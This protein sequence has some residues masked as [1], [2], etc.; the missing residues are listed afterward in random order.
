MLK[1]LCKKMF[2]KSL[3]V[4]HCNSG[5][6]NGCDIE[7]L[8]ILTPYYDVERFGIKLVGSPRHADV[9]LIS[10]AVTRPTLP[11]VKKAYEAMPN[12]KL[13]FAIGSCA[14]G[15]GAWFDTYNVTGG[16]NKAVPINYYI[17]GCPPR[18]EAILYGVAL[19]LGLVDKKVAPIELK[20]MEFP[21]DVYERNKAWEER[22]V[23]YKLLEEP[24][25][26]KEKI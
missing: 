25:T 19:A 7:I 23:I 20:Q 13:V 21:I 1:K 9:M 10:G 15:G 26:T 22:N 16:A 11:L 4:F 2:T 3:W 18:P 8:N 14:T 17:P 6:C 5:A 24:Q 12:P